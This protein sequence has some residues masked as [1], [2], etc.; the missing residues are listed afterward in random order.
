MLIMVCIVFLSLFTLTNKLPISHEDNLDISNEFDIDNF[1]AE[2][3]LNSIIEE[4][5]QEEINNENTKSSS[6]IK[7]VDFKGTASIMSKLTRLDIESHINNED[8]KFNWIELMSLL[9]CKYG[10]EFSKFK[11]AD[12]DTIVNDLKSGKTVTE[13]SA[14]YKLYNY[15]YESL[16]AI[17]HEYVGKYSIQ[18]GDVSGNKIYKTDY[19][20][21]VFSPIAQ[22]YSFSH[23]KDFGASR[24]YGYKRVH[25]GNDILR[26]YWNPYCCCGIRICRG[27]RLESIWWLASRNS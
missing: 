15:Y 27:A 17:F 9:A 8:V 12:L 24:S 23:Y 5:E 26:Q 16:D 18:V 11:Q 6:Y 3:Y 1:S 10:G 2:D 19:G 25:L 4:V 7:W 20:I 13:L 14:N 21:K 22:G